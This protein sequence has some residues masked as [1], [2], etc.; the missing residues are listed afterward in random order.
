MS[1]DVVAAVTSA[2]SLPQLRFRLLANVQLSASSVNLCNGNQYITA[3]ATTYSP[4]GGFGGVEPVRETSELFPRSLVMWL[5]AI[6]SANLAEPLTENLFSKRVQLYRAFLTDSHT[7]ISTPHLLF[8]GRIN[9]VDIRMGDPE[10]GNYYEIEAESRLY[11]RTTPIYFSQEGYNQLYAGVYSGDTTF[12][13]IEQ[14]F[15]FKAKWGDS[16][17][18]FDGVYGNAPANVGAWIRRH[19]WGRGP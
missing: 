10:R 6:N 17:T 16:I 2:A 8:Q 14:M 4:I 7:L 15:G 9:R 5:S 19:Y 18:R 12:K 3:G 11:R 13:Y 1:R